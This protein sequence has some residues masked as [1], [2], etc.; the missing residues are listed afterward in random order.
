MES[1]RTVCDLDDGLRTKIVSLALMR[2]ELGL[3]HK[4][5]WPWPLASH[6]P[7]ISVLSVMSSYF[8]SLQYRTEQTNFLDNF[9]DSIT[10][11]LI[12]TTPKLR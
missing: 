9:Y 6:S 11:R 3:E 7:V 5:H 8:I 1:S 4:D 12:I 10:V 2:S